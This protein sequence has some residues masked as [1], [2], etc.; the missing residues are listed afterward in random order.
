MTMKRWIVVTVITMVLAWVSA[1]YGAMKV[2]VSIP[3]QKW[4]VEAVGG[5]LVSVELLVRA[6]QDPHTFEPRPK[7]V[8]ALSRAKV[9][10]TLGMEF[11]KR[12][13]EKVQ[14]VAPGLTV[15]DMS[16]EVEKVVMVEDGHEHGGH[17]SSGHDAHG[18]E[19]LDPH[20]WLSPVNLQIMSRTVAETLAAGD[21]A[22]G[23][24]YRRKQMVVEAQ[25]ETLNQKLLEMLK[26]Y[27]GAS[28]FVFHP[29]FGY[30]GNAYGLVQEPVE[31]E[32]KSPGPRQ[33]SAL[34]AK[35]KAQQVKVIFVQP[36]FDPKAA[37]AVAAAI[38]GS[39][40][41]LDSLA[42]DVP[43][44]LQVMATKIEDALKK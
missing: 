24:E 31:L 30:F 22:N 15:I 14:A 5:E 18:E 19:P 17:D 25:L 1:S 40:V 26:P 8:A 44:N 33:L 10:Y 2:F 9:W 38:G 29:S 42:E 27:R 35:A 32:G 21:P 13:Q 11:E 4:L 36:Q 3:P 41:P 20:V 16:R 6:G 39:V 23:E 43:A 37:Q 28:F 7:Q 12:L 34:I